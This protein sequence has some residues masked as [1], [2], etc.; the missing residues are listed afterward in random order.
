MSH[1]QT[2]P[3]RAATERVDGALLG[4]LR[5]LGVDADASSRRLA[6]YAYDASNYRVSPV[7]VVFPR[8]VD[9]VVATV[10]ACRETGTPLTARG[11]GTS[12]AGNAIGPGVV[13]DFSRHLNR[14]RGVDE[15]AG[16]VDVDPGVVL[17]DLTRRVEEV[18]DGRATFAPDPSSKTR[19][20]VGGSIGN[21][22]CGN[23]SVRYG[24]TSD[25][26]QEIDVVTVDG[27]R[28]TA[29][30]TGLRATDPDDRVSIAR[31]A[32]LTT[33]LRRL[34]QDNLAT[35]R[36]ELGR[37]QRQVSGYH[38]EH[39]LPE[40]EFDVARALVGSE[41]TCAVVVGARMTLVP[42][43]A[44]ALLVCLG[45]D[46]IVDAARDVTTILE[47]SPAA[48]EGT[49][50]A[51]VE[52]MRF[53]RGPDSVLGLP[54]GHA[55]LFVDLDGDDAAAVAAE[56]DR[57]L[58][59][60]ATDGR[61][62]EGRAV[63]DLGHR[64]SLWRVR[65]DG[66]GLSSRLAGGGESWPGWEDSAVS[67]NRLADYLGDLR[68]L[69]AEHGLTGVMY[70]HF[71]AGCLHIRITYDLRTEQGRT[72]FR[73]FT[74]AAARLVVR[75]GG[76]LSGEH[77]DGRARSELLPLMYSADLLAAFQH[78]RRLWDPVGI[79]NLGSMTEPDAFDAHL[80][81]EGVPARDWRTSF[82][83]RAV[84]AG[85]E[86]TEATAS[87]PDPWVHAVQGCIGVGRCR[88]DTGGVM[89]PSYR[90]TRD[91]KDSTRGR[92][93]V[94]QDMVRGAR[95]TGDGWR[96]PEV[97]EA[98][99]LCL[100]CKACATDCPA[101]VDMATYKAEFFDHY[102]RRRLR[103][104]SHFS[105]GWLPRWLV[106]TGRVAPLVNAVLA[107]PLGK[108]AAVAGG[109][110]T[111]RRLPRF[112]P[113][114]AWCRE[115]AAAGVSPA[116]A[117]GDRDAGA[118]LFIDTFTRGFRPEVAGAAARV[119]AGAGEPVTCAAD[120]CCGLTWIS[121]GQLDTARKR[122]AKAAAALDDG[123]NRPIV[124]VEPS[125]AAA[126]HTDLPELVP[127]EQARR[128]AARVRSFATHVAER[129]ATG[130]TPAPGRP[131]PERVVLQTHCHE[132]SAFGAGPQ[133]AALTAAGVQQIHDATGCCGVAG[134]FGFEAQHH[135]ISMQVAENAL[136]PALRESGP[137]AVVLT[138][139]FSCARQIEQLDSTR[140]GRHLA[141]ILDPGAP[142]HAGAA[143]PISDDPTNG[144]EDTP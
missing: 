127:T 55:W 64:A 2:P 80:A 83:L 103:P 38:L 50:E 106:L 19:A 92:A 74:R 107:T 130:W 73:A 131:V 31:A 42:K 139:G 7:A 68:L 97:R 75:H 113:A 5:E 63:P 119:L 33:S 71:G 141:Q 51:I 72:V 125:C 21:D 29:H 16:T 35:F 36:L 54:A 98:L 76:S 121:T 56:A 69:L 124:V 134:N 110:T 87:A 105:L 18:T 48:V 142:V 143:T 1:V 41:G 96:S 101:G 136:A 95:T 90:A 49:D 117:H 57:L 138:D 61:L 17:A 116:G 24:R 79:L 65:E 89:C 82:D 70:G 84:G 126:L 34:A 10:R 144:N 27:A 14:I 47:F 112:A 132:Y 60:L 99:D 118:V 109:L 135:E 52:T 140:S 13:L 8:N 30:R 88:A 66:A 26:V 43:P 58:V 15:A 93:R 122:L 86:P 59:R 46:D 32:E 12:M 94:L 40:R 53:R 45:Y 39:L 11:G 114:D 44:T 77:G 23:H 3:G 133:R 28:L 91:E 67:P 62:V 9:E 128:V 102:Y 104:A 22:A 4:R 120:A 111:K 37:I 129:A 81:L 137:G 25:H 85:S 115:V 20:T 100:S 123:T 6:E 108:L 78:Y